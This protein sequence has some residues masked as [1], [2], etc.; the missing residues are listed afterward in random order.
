MGVL[1]HFIEISWFGRPKFAYCDSW[2]WY[3]A[4]NGGQG[5]GKSILVPRFGQL[6]P[7]FGPRKMV[8][9]QVQKTADYH[10]QPLGRYL[11]SKIAKIDQN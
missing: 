7:N 4:T 11:L 2:Q 5:A 9:K 1:G 10:L 3:I 6:R 8:K